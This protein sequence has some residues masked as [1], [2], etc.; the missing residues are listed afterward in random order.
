M[1]TLYVFL[2][3]VHL[4]A[5][6]F[7]G[8]MWTAL[9]LCGA[10][11]L[12]SRLR[13]IRAVHFGSL[14]LVPLYLGLNFAFTKLNV[15]AGHQAVFP[16]GFALFVGFVVVASLFPRSDGARTA[17]YDWGQRGALVLTMA[18]LACLAGAMLWTAGVLI[19]Y[20]VQS[21]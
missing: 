5:I 21:V 8:I 13:D 18:G 11:W 4:T 14:Y 9:E 12:R 7:T 19:L 2:A 16:A 10:P 1:T 15:A 17:A 20:S 3:A 6:V